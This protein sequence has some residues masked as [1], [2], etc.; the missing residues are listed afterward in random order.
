M[1]F[2]EFLR[3]LT[4]PPW[5]ALLPED[6]QNKLPKLVMKIARED[7]AVK[8]TQDGGFDNSIDAAAF[9][10]FKK[11]DADQTGQL[12]EASVRSMLETVWDSSGQCPPNEER[13]QKEVANTMQ[14]FANPETQGIDVDNFRALVR[15]KPFWH[16][17]PSELID[18]AKA[19][20]RAASPFK[21]RGRRGSG[22]QKWAWE[23]GDEPG[24]AVVME[25]AQKLFEQFDVDGN[26]AIDEE[27]LSNL[28]QHLMS[29]L[30]KPFLPSQRMG[31][32][33]EVRN[34]M[35]KFDTN[36]DGVLNFQEFAR[37]LTMAPWR[38]LFPKDVQHGLPIQVMK[39]NLVHGEFAEEH[40]AS[41]AAQDKLEDRPPEGSPEREGMREATSQA[42]GRAVIRA[43]KML[44]EEA[45]T[46]KNG[47]IDE[48]ELAVL[49]HKLW[50][51]LGTPMPA[52]YRMKLMSEVRNAMEVFDADNT[53]TIS[54]G[55][56]LRMLTVSPWREL[57][58]A[59]VQEQL[60][61]MVKQ[62]ISPQKQQNS[63]E[64]AAD[65]P[66]HVTIVR[67]AKDL[68]DRTD[69]NG[70]GKIEEEELV[71]L[72]EEVWRKLGRAV[73]SHLREEVHDAMLV[74]D[75]DANGSMSFF[76]FVRL[77]ARRPWKV[78]L[79]SEVQALLPKVSLQELQKTV[80]QHY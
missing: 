20:A 56:F 9:R 32:V 38:N 57:L 8:E 4:R 19:E 45:D 77:I 22:E 27:E 1:S 2:P 40:R 67:A 69:A 58:P 7:T 54:E 37:M 73:T 68:F 28:L 3:M 55:E 13:K 12:G 10:L 48:E 36:N 15:A 46:S 78:L 34:T 63:V 49:L 33:E 17:L 50:A 52:D 5:K 29:T 74:F 70:D 53:G 79:P 41:R 51:R 42:A 60:P 61:E 43:A 80:S 25:T 71:Q 30:G 64:A 11:F 47:E 39:H 14:Q 62:E 18:Q 16:L 44:F 24:A 21:K 59:D 6:V 65:E 72:C 66:S 76:E 23:G 75:K 31:L 26:S 35:R